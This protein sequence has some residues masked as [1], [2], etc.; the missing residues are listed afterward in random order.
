MSWDVLCK[1]TLRPLEEVRSEQKKSLDWSEEMEEEDKKCL[2]G[3]DRRPANRRLIESDN[4]NERL[5]RGR[6]PDKIVFQNEDIRYRDKPVEGYTV[7]FN[8]ADEV[9]I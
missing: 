4:N 9:V 1:G 5:Q 3:A 6:L 8:P 7:V 2:M